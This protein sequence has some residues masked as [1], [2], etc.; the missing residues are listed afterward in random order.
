MQTAARLTYR[1][2]LPEEFG[3]APREVPGSEVY[4]P[5]NSRIFAA[6]DERGDVVASFTM[7]MAPHLEPMWIRPDHRHSASILR[8]MADGMKGMLRASGI[9]AAYSVVLDETPVLHRFA[10]FFGGERVAGVLYFWK[11]KS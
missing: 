10:E 1:E 7:F 4:T 9:P 2:L 6:L 11:E 3:K 5:A 8:R